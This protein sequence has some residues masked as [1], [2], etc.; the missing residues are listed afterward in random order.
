MHLLHLALRATAFISSPSFALSEPLEIEEDT[1]DEMRDSN[2]LTKWTEPQHR[3]S[4]SLTTVRV[5][6]SIR[7]RLPRLR[8]QCSIHG[9]IPHFFTSWFPNLCPFPPAMSPIHGMLAYF[10]S[11]G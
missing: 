1:N 8:A 6:H 3:T 10:D 9:L 7:S 5:C 11:H 2:R 4:A